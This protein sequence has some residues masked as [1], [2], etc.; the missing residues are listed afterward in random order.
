[1]FRIGSKLW[2]GLSK[3]GEEATEVSTVCFKIIGV[4]GT[5]VYW[6]G[7]NL[8]SRLAA[9]L[10]DLLAATDYFIAHALS[11]TEQSQVAKVRAEQF[12]LYMTWHARQKE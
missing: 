8:R 3:L 7:T 10:G 9:E 5:A 6:D 4:G 11:P 1:M 2:P 12:E